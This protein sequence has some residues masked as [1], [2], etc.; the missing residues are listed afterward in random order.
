MKR[1]LECYIQE[2]PSGKENLQALVYHLFPADTANCIQLQPITTGYKK[3]L[4][5]ALNVKFDQRPKENY[6]KKLIFYSYFIV[7]FASLRIISIFK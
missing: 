3:S 6:R 4:V 2:K 5:F 7:I 1:V